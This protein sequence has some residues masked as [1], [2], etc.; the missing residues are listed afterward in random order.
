MKVILAWIFAVLIASAAAGPASAEPV[1]HAGQGVTEPGVATALDG[2][3]M[4][5]EIGTLYVPEN[6]DKP[7]SRLIGVGFARVR[8]ARPTGATAARRTCQPRCGWTP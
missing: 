8:A 3:T 7:G 1:H 6:G 5:Y 4:A 2:S